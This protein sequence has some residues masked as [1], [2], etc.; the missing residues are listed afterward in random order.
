MLNDKFIID[1]HFVGYAQLINNKILH[2]KMK[3][4]IFYLNCGEQI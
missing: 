2:S 3:D 1:P 4:G